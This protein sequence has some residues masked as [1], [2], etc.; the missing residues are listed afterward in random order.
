M[1][2]VKAKFGSCFASL[3][4]ED[5]EVRR[6]I[7]EERASGENM[8]GITF[9]PSGRSFVIQLHQ[10]SRLH[11]D[12]R[13]EVDGV[14]KSWAIP[15]GP[16][17]NP[18]VKRL[19]IP[20]E[21]H[22]LAYANFEGLIAEGEY[23]AGIVMIWDRGTYVPVGTNDVGLALQEGEL[24]FTLIG[25]K[26]KGSWTLVRIKPRAWLLIKHRDSHASEEN[27]TKLEPRSVV[28]HRLLSQI[29]DDEEGSANKGS[30]KQ[31]VK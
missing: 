20:V 26:L 25:M 21:D 7:R 2:G 12:F 8:R 29:A 5:E 19:A 31:G 14:L 16:S 22:S 13:L 15:K 10:A 30:S 17:L 24:K 6:R 3:H 28:S 27:I 11:Y 4:T 1:S 18:S 23:G 9:S